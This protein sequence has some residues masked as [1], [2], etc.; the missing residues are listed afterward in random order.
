MAFYEGLEA[1]LKMKYRCGNLVKFSTLIAIFCCSFL[2]ISGCNRDDDTINKPRDIGDINIEVIDA[3]TRFGFNLF[4]EIRKTENNKNIFISPFSVSVA[5]VMTLNGASGETEQSMTDA[6]QLQGIDPETINTGYATLQQVLQTSDPKVTLTIANSLWAH[7]ANDDFTFYPDFLQVNK[8]FFNAEITELNLHDPNTPA[9]INQWVDSNTNGKIRKMIDKIDKET[10]LLLLNAIYFKGE[11]KTEFEPSMTQNDPFYLETGEE[12]SVP[13]MRRVDN[14][15]YYE[16]ENFQVVSLPY[17]SGYMSMYIFLP[18]SE[19]NLNTLL[20]DL[21]AESWENA[22]SQVS[23]QEVY[24]QI[25]KF[26]LEYSIDLSDALKELGMEIAF[27][28]RNADFSRMAYSPTGKPLRRWIQKVNQKTFV[29]VNEEGTEAAAVTAVEVGMVAESVSIPPEF[30][31]D[32]PFFYAIYD[33]DLKTV[34]FMG[35]VVDPQ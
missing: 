7:N 15:A 18:S 23:E 35:T 28:E 22:V 24:V 33:N 9:H 29:K 19:S 25:P 34:L 21:N 13:M 8:E 30:I 31:A 20:D 27:D 2:I 17:G 3:N 5:L 10:G 14:Y 32:R 16:G 1:I 4:N 26:E 6:L 12:K 11:W